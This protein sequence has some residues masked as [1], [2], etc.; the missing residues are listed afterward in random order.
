MV[1]KYGQDT[2]DILSSMKIP[3]KWADGELNLLI[4][5]YKKKVKEMGN[6]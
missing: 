5:E 3:Y 6:A 4:S 1:R 2:V